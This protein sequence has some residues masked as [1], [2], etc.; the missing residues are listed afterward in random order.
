[1]LRKAM[2]I[3]SFEVTSPKASIM[4]T[5]IEGINPDKHRSGC[6]IGPPLDKSSLNT[7]AKMPAI[8]RMPEIFSSRREAYAEKRDSALPPK[9]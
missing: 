1:M 9:L 2:E 4:E 5:P 8:D 6:L 7:G 3:D